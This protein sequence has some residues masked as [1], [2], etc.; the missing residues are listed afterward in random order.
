MNT[1]PAFVDRKHKPYT[2]M[3]VNFATLMT[4]LGGLHAVQS[5]CAAVANRDINTRIP[6]N[7]PLAS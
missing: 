2:Y 7:K 1:K 5:S 4:C 6:T 3:D